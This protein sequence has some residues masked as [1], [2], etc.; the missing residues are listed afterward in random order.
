MRR[1]KKGREAE[2]PRWQEAGEI[3]KNNATLRD[4]LQKEKKKKE[5]EPGFKGA[6]GRKFELPVPN[7]F[8]GS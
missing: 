3:G 1:E 4:I 2:F 8:V 7:S 6:R 5:Q